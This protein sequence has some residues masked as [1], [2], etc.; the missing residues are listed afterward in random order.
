MEEIDKYL[1]YMEHRKDIQ[2]LEARIL[3]YYFNDVA[4]DEKER[5]AEWFGIT[6]QREGVINKETDN[7]E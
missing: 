5:Y 7:G 2:M 3:H 4:N 6:G 1:Q